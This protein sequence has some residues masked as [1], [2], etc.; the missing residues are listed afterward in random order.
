MTSAWI[1]VLLPQNRKLHRFDLMHPGVPSTSFE[2]QHGAG[3]AGFPAPDL[4]IDA[5]GFLQFL[6]QEFGLKRS[7]R[8]VRQQQEDRAFPY[9][10]WGR[11][12]FFSPSQIRAAL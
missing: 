4:L 5:N 3:S 12:V 7:V 11:K 1:R 10:R 9:I 8:W 6:L 2:P